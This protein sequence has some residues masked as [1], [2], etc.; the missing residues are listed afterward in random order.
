MTDKK[1][2]V[3]YFASHCDNFVGDNQT[4]FQHYLRACKR[5]VSGVHDETF[6]LCKTKLQNVLILKK[7]RFSEKV[8][9]HL[10]PASE[11]VLRR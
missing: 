2:V 10:K 7:F 3:R 5:A 11:A 8:S 6:P 1:Q 4:L 9:G